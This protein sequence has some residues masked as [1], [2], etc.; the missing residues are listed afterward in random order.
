M[1]STF[2]VFAGKVEI[3]SIIKRKSD[4]F[5]QG[6]QFSGGKFYESCGLYGSSSWRVL[7]SSWNVLKTKKIANSYFAEGLVY[8][9]GQI[10]QLTWENP[11][12]LFWNVKLSKK[13]S[14]KKLPLPEG[15][16]ISLHP[17]G[18][19]V[20]DGSSKLSLLDNEFSVIKQVNVSFN[21]KDVKQLNE[22]ESVGGL[23]LAN[24]WQ[25]NF[26]LVIDPNSGQVIETWDA[27]ALFSLVG[28]KQIADVLNGIAW[29]SGQKRLWVTGKKWDRVFEIKLPQSLIYQQ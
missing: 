26:I 10:I 1:G 28:D 16:G 7:D 4:C 24:V 13:I 25:T 14:E 20:S 11:K 12:V 18:Y 22:L 3:V 27:S 29:D 19:Y 15:W 6:L 21:Q 8:R 2:K 9:N 5:T 17:Q 23:V